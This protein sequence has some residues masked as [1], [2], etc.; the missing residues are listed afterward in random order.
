[1]S[2]YGQNPVFPQD[3]ITGPGPTPGSSTDNALVRWDGTTGQEV[4][5][6]VAVLTDAGALT[7]LTSLTVT[8]LIVTE[9]ITTGD[10]I[11]RLNDEVVGTPTENAGIEIERGSST[12]A[13]LLWD[14][15]LDRWSAGLSGSLSPIVRAIDLTGSTGAI[16]WT[17]TT[18]LVSSLAQTLVSAMGSISTASSSFSDMTTMTITPIA[19]TYMVWLSVEAETAADGG[20]EIRIVRGGAE[21]SNSLREFSI[22]NSSVVD[23]ATMTGSI[24][25]IAVVNV[26]GSQAIVG[27]FRSI[28]GTFTVT[29]R[30][31]MILKVS[32]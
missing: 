12:D 20:G 28:T 4:Q 8:T 16:T 17:G 1:M 26:S 29:N 5:N 21:Q 7:G 14:E 15:T 31:M 10:N 11:I 9:T 32:S 18:A 25:T 27:Q 6:S 30:T 24:S 13:Q 19:G 2:F 22:V 3:G 23:T